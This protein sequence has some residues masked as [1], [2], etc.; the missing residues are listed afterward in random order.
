[1]D[2]MIIRAGLKLKM[3]SQ[4]MEKAYKSLLRKRTVY[5]TIKEITA[6]GR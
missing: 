4:N 2:I 5:V 6:T 3:K 1:M